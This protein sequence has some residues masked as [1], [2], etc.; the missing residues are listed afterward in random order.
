MTLFQT[1]NEN[2][3]KLITSWNVLI[4]CIL[5]IVLQNKPDLNQFYKAEGRNKM[6]K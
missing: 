6:W 3:K 1:V 4:D 2:Y 5:S